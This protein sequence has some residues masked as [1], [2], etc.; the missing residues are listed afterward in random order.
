MTALG[1]VVA[2]AAV[3]VVGGYIGTWG[4]LKAEARR[5]AWEERTVAR[6]RAMEDAARANVQQAQDRA[7]AREAQLA[8]ITELVARLV[9]ELEARRGPPED[10]P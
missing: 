6:W 5:R 3:V 8:E 1:W 7:R 4:A 10:I 2:C 9:V